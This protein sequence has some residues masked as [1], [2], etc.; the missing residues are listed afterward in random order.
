MSSISTSRSSSRTLD[1]WGVSLRKA[2][3]K[4]QYADLELMVDDR[5]V[6]KK[7][8]NLYE[9]AM[10]YPNDS[11]QPLEVVVTSIVKNHIRGYISA[12]K[13]KAS[14]LTMMSGDAAPVA[15]T[16]QNVG[17]QPQLRRR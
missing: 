2:N 4:H 13:Y 14:Q 10:F 8:L 6:S 5:E 12:P 15:T 7:R 1:R 11:Q 16:A 17:S 3:P 9:P